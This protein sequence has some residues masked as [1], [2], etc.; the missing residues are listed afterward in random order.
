MEAEPNGSRRSYHTLEFWLALAAMLVSIISYIVGG[1]IDNPDS[2]KFLQVLGM[3]GT[4]LSGLGY[5][6]LRTLQKNAEAK[7][8]AIMAAANARQ[9]NPR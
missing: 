3:I 5:G 2:S 1:V 6:G 4:M 9:N 8:D 7:R